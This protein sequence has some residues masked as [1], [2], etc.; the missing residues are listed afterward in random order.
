MPPLIPLDARPP[1]EEGFRLIAKIIARR[2]LRERKEQQARTIAQQTALPDRKEPPDVDPSP[3]PPVP[4][5]SK[6]SR[7][8]VR[9]RRG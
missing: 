2:I 9:R 3:Q 7:S 4:G 6:V 5:G 1:V 8:S